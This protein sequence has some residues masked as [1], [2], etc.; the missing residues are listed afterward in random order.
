MRFTV[1][2][3]TLAEGRQEEQGGGRLRL[4]AA[5]EW[6]WL[7]LEGA[8]LGP[9]FLTSQ[10]AEK[11]HS[12]MGHYFVLYVFSLVWTDTAADLGALWPLGRVWMDSRGQV[13]VRGRGFQLSV[14]NLSLLFKSIQNLEIERFLIK[15]ISWSH[16]CHQNQD[17]RDS[18]NPGE[19]TSQS[20]RPTLF[21]P[22]FY[23]ST[24]FNFTNCSQIKKR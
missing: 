8:Q 24:S 12:V 5:G 15:E 16:V 6:A 13:E 1:S 20:K 19:D 14:R 21:F 23:K 17:E 2:W 10:P 18:Q 4:A 3:L 9:C 22:K 7:K 11:K